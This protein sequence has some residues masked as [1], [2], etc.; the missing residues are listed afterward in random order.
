MSLLISTRCEVSLR[1]PILSALS[2]SLF[3]GCSSNELA[4]LQAENKRLSERTQAQ[5]A[6]IEN[7]KVHSREVEDQLLTA[8]QQ[9]A[10]GSGGRAVATRQT[11][12]GSGISATS[13][14]QLAALSEK[15]SY[16]HY[17]PKTGIAKVDTDILFDSG[18]A[19]LK[20]GA[21]QLLQQLV[22]MLK[23]PTGQDLKVMV[24]GHTDDQRIKGSEA[25][26]KYPNNWHL[27]TARAN[28]V[29]D[30]LRT[31]G[32]D[33]KRM[34]VAGFGEYQSI[35]TNESPQ[36]RQQNRRV[37]IFLTAPDV[38]IVGMTETMTNLY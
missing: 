29:A 7:L 26:G 30:Q 36:L 8:E 22:S 3:V 14:Q 18:E 25:L 35:A 6:E 24:V 12:T 21:Q 31:L 27:S 10:S 34:G 13:S 2:L 15:Y 28:T 20:P 33:G 37:E 23:S 16:L 19:T 11:L 32:L 5:L 38:P 4:N 9:L 1:W 17:D